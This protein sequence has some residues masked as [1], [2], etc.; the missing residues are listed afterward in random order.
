MID[1]V[2]KQEWAHGEKHLDFKR[3]GTEIK[4][5]DTKIFFKL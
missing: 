1:F 2:L 4:R 5:K 3:L